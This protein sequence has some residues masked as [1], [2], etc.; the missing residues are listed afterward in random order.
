M[1]GEGRQLQASRGGLGAVGAGLR[2]CRD[3]I[4][5]GAIGGRQGRNCERMIGRK[6][7][8]GHPIDRVRARGEDCDRVFASLDREIDPGVIG[9]SLRLS[10]TCNMRGESTLVPF[11]RIPGS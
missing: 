1:Y 10:I 3:L 9:A 7:K 4:Q 5:H 2:C 8:K 6:A 11:A